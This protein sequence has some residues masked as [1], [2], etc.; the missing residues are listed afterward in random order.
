MSAARVFS[1]ISSVVALLL[2]SACVIQLVEKIPWHDALYFSSTTLTTVGFGDVV[3]RTILGKLAIIC[4]VLVGVVAIPVRASQ[5][6]QFLMMRRSMHGT[7]PS[8]QPFVLMASRLSDIRAFGDLFTE[9]FHEMESQVNWGRVQ[10]GKKERRAPLLPS[11][12]GRTKLVVVSNKPSFEFQAF[13]ELNFRRL[14][15][16]EGSVLSEADLNFVNARRARA[17]LLVAD[18]FSARPQ[19]EDK[20]LIF[21]VWS[22][23]SY[24]RDVPLLVQ[25]ISKTAAHQIAPF[26]DSRR[27]SVI[28]LED[29]RFSL[30]AF[31]VVCPG[32]STL[33]GN[34]LRSTVPP[35]RQLFQSDTMAGMQWLRQY[36]DGSNHKLRMV[37]CNGSFRG[38]D[39]SQAAECLYRRVG[40]VL[41]GVRTAGPLSTLL[42]NPASMVLRADEEL[43]VLV[44]SDTQAKR[45]GE[46]AYTE[47]FPPDIEEEATLFTAETLERGVAPEPAGDG[48][49]DAGQGPV[50]A[51]L[52]DA[53][54][55]KL[56]MAVARD[57]EP[58]G[59]DAPSDGTFFSE[60]ELAEGGD[61]YPAPSRRSADVTDLL[62]DLAPELGV[63]PGSLDSID[64]EG[65]PGPGEL[66]RD[67]SVEEHNEALEGTG[68]RVIGKNEESGQL[69]VHRSRAP[70]EAGGD[71]GIGSYDPEGSVDFEV[72]EIVLTAIEDNLRQVQA[73][74]QADEIGDSREVG[75]GHVVV[76]GDPDSFLVFCRTVREI[77]CQGPPLV[78]V[79]PGELDEELQR[80]LER[81]GDV[82]FIRGSPSDPASL[83]AARVSQARAFVFLASQSRQRGSIQGGNTLGTGQGGLGE[84]PHT[85]YG[86]TAWRRSVLADAEAL[87]TCYTVG[88]GLWDVAAVVELCHTSSV[89]FVQPG[90]LLPGV[91]ETYEK[92]NRR[93][94]PFQ[95]LERALFG[96]PQRLGHLQKSRQEEA[97]SDE[98]LASWQVNSF[99]AAG[100]IM[101]PALLDTL[102]AQAF[103]NPGLIPDF[104]RELQGGASRGGTLLRQLALPA[105]LVGRTYGDLVSHLALRQRVVP[106]GLYRKKAENATWKLPYVHTNPPPGTV[107]RE[108]DRVFVLRER[109]GA[110]DT[111]GAE[112]GE[113]RAG[114]C[115]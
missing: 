84:A 60:R 73:S 97:A 20:T 44:S 78:V 6:Y 49:G 17:A 82:T 74:A 99:Y 114:D 93:G 64:L 59:G 5:V 40:V 92:I 98:G 113:S 83:K 86:N 115:E 102:T 24:T 16:V 27:D 67:K 111:P 13:Q 4:V 57:A 41:M 8:F 26:L 52:M 103:F 34:M 29:V 109:G 87:M 32:A 46:V 105:G 106:L 15:L 104:F 23:R 22:I 10:R 56:G 108:D 53:A 71:P 81:L 7:V 2:T 39:F 31:S 85:A 95:S 68:L 30:L 19:E 75:R 65:Y 54:R 55:A 9:F 94:G 35:R 91:E 38:V 33:L 3:P 107:L 110:C 37:P 25:T 62:R 51:G 88:E 90:M 66:T 100:R 112:G 58:G 36:V 18:R 76:S 80:K 14:T 12:P 48:G 77:D 89:R 21:Q 96:A 50:A 70:E 43:L 45:C 1:L 72:D 61:A 47:G 11:N 79:H 101:V 42:L 28:S 63:P 69:V